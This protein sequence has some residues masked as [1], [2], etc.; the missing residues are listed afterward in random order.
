[1]YMNIANQA[2]FLHI[3]KNQT[4]Q[5]YISKV[6]RRGVNAMCLC[7]G[8]GSYSKTDVGAKFLSRRLAGFMSDQ[9][10]N[11]LKLPEV[12]IVRRTVD[13]IR[14]CISELR[15]CG[16]CDSPNAYA[17]TAICCA[18]EAATG[19]YIAVQ[20]GDG[21]L[22]E[23]R[24]GGVRR[25][26]RQI[27]YGQG[28][29]ARATMLSTASPRALLSAVQVVR[30]QSDGVLM[31]SDGAEGWLYDRFG[32]ARELSGKLVDSVKQVGPAMA[33]KLLA[34]TARS[35][36]SFDDISIGLMIRGNPE[37]D[38]LGFVPGSV[39]PHR[40]GMQKKATLKK[41]SEYSRN[42]DRGLSPK[43]STRHA[44]WGRR[45]S[46]MMMTYSSEK[47]CVY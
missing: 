12:E 16:G 43:V 2:G 47:L 6:C 36:K 42:R 28:D 23:I 8:A 45:N 11:L 18:M 33:E 39:I 15:L 41:V 25:L 32:N 31:C 34:H 26:I 21:F 30:G 40:R 29:Q 44:Q 5:D 10:Y 17:S 7:D 14:A 22:G 24:S 4:S 38:A 19:R 3:E 35:F 1:M 46:R 37:A 13:E 9:F 27:S 20:L